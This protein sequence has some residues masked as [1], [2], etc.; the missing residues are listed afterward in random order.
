MKAFKQEKKDGIAEIVE[1]TRSIAILSEVHPYEPTDLDISFA[2]ERARA[3]NKNQFDLFYMQSVL[4]SVGW[5][6]NDDV[7]DVA[8][9]WNA[10]STPEDKQF[11]F[12]HNEK[13]II[14]HITNCYAIDRNGKRI[15]EDIEFK[16]LPSEFDIVVGSV[17]YKSWS[18][19][20]LKDRMLKIISEIENVDNYNDSWY[21]SMECLFPSFDYA[22]VSPD[23]RQEVVKREESSAFL[24]KHLRAY[25]GSGE[26]NGYKVGRV[27]RNFSFSGIG[28]VNK[29]ANPRS[30]ILNNKKT[31]A[32]E[33][34]MQEDLEVLK[35]ELAE[36]KKY[37]EEMEKKAKES[38]AETDSAV[39]DLLAK[40][41]DAQEA[42]AAEKTDKEKMAEEMKKMKEK[43]AMNEEELMKMK[44]EKMMMK[45]KAQ[46]TE[47]GFAEAELDET[48]S[49]FETLADEMFDVVVAAMKAKQSYVEKKE[50]EKPAE[51][52]GKK[53]KAEIELD[54]N[55]A[56]AEILDSAEAS[57]DIPMAV[58]SELEE[59]LRSTASEW[60]GKEVLKSTKSLSK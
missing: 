51:P 23:G 59:S 37:N 13:D 50:N 15:P 19:K 11:N 33:I 55:E 7:F 49:K 4:A 44:K 56:E 22:M 60:F 47:V 31:K 18:N 34:N 9:M 3:E 35:A 58:E 27:L 20:E 1:N 30:I 25:G 41:S 40:L 29:P 45:R 14:G 21:V 42:L 46:L 2:M 54:E 43:A 6:K 16:T 26:Y 38:K 52:V 48:L 5:N 12:M 17:L 24:T 32:E 8:E 10:R 39:A 36:A 28:L 53:V 57:E